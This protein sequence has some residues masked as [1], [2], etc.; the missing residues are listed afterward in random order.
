MLLLSPWQSTSKKRGKTL[1]KGARNGA[2]QGHVLFHAVYICSYKLRSIHIRA[3][4]HKCG[5]LLVSSIQPRKENNT[6]RLIS[7]LVH[8]PGRVTSPTVSDD[9]TPESYFPQSFQRSAFI[10]LF[11]YELNKIPCNTVSFWGSWSSNNHFQT[12]FLRLPFEYN[13]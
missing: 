7:R 10:C 3:K 11:W 2:P 9:K 5:S 12:A 1:I 6:L 8:G 4:A 13:S